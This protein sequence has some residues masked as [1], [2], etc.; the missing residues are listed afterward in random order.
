MIAHFVLGH[1]GGQQFFALRGIHPVKTRPG[2]GRRCNPKMHLGRPSLEHHF[3]DL[4]AGG[5]AHH[6][7]VDQNDPLAA[8][9]G[10]VDVQF[11]P[12]TH[13]ADLFG[14]FNK[15][16]ADIL[17]ADDPHRIG[18]PRLQAIPDGSG[19]A[20]IRHRADQIGINRGLFGQFAADRLARFIDRP[21]TQNRIRAAEIHM[22]KDAEPRFLAAE[23]EMRFDAFGADDDHFAGFNL[24]L[25]RGTDDIQRT[26]FR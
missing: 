11:Q 9:Q 18:N 3:T 10:A 14:G 2:G 19:G 23:R 24:A 6:R 21:A 5:A 20:G 12:H 22:F 26:G 1:I 7:I 17:V 8:H 4:D 13:V 16:A 15:R 25:E